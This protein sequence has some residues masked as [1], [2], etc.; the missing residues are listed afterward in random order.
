MMKATTD[1][2]VKF[3]TNPWWSMGQA[4]PGECGLSINETATR[5]R[6]GL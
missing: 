4:L 1:T 6:A 3:L 5:A 2:H